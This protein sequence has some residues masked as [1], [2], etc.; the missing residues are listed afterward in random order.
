[1]I[2]LL[3]RQPNDTNT[4]KA[5]ADRVRSALPNAEEYV[6]EVKPGEIMG[7]IGRNG[8]GKTTTFRMLC[9]LLPATSGMLNVAG[10]NLRRAP[11]QARGKVGYVAQKFSLYGNL[12]VLENLLFFG[13]I[14]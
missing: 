3:N 10:E 2:C 4:K 6:F 1:M 7:F 11:A 14:Q 9:G 5:A 12:T 8:A 13:K